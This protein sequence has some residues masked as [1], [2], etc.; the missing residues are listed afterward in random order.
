MF[1]RNFGNIQ[2]VVGQTFQRFGI[3]KDSHVISVKLDT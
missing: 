1:N 3:K 2:E